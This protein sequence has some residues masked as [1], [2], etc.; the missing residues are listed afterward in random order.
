[1]D[2]RLNYR[3][4]KIISKK[5]KIRDDRYKPKMTDSSLLRENVEHVLIE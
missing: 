1:M 3:Y 2:V 5:T 4:G